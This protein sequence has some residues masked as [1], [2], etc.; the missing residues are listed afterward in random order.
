MLLTWLR[1]VNPQVLEQY[2]TEWEQIG[3][4]LEGVYQK[5]VDSVSKVDGQ[6]WQG[7]AADAAH[8]RASADLKT[9]QAL[10]DKLNGLA[11]QART[12]ATLINEALRK[13]R[14][15]LDEC[16]NKGWTV[17]ELLAVIGSGNVRDL[18][19]MN[20]DLTAAYNAVVAAD[21]A[22]MDALN[23]TRSG[24]TVAFTSGASLG[25]EQ[26]KNDG[27]HVG[28]DPT[29][30]TDAERQ[31]LIDAGT[32][33]D[34][35]LTDLHNG[36]TV[37]IPVAQ[38]DYINQLARSLD[39]KSPQ[40]IQAIVDSLPP[41][42]STALRNS[43]Q[44]VST[45]AIT[46]AVKGDPNI[47]DHGDT[48]LLPAKL[49]QSLTRPDLVNTEVKTIGGGTYARMTT[50]TNLNGV[51]DNQS[52]AKIAG[53]ADPRYR[54]GTGLDKQLLDVG[55]KYLN[56][57]VTY[58][59]APDHAERGFTVDGH[60]VNS[61]AALTEGIFSAVGDDKAAVQNLVVDASGKPNDQF[62]HDVLTHTWTDD[63]KAASKLFAF[64]DNEPGSVDA[65]RQATIMSAFAQFASTDDAPSHIAGGNDKWHLYDIPGTD[66]QTVGDLNPK[67]VQTLST[68]MT[69]YIDDLTNPTHPTNDG[70]KV[71]DV[72]GDSWTD[73]S[74]NHTFT[75]SKNIFSFMDTNDLAGQ[76]FN[77]AAL[78]ASM[79]HEI[80][81]GQDPNDPHARDQLVDSG[82]LQGLVDA[83][84]RDEISAH[85]TD[86]AKV[87]ADAYNQKKIAYETVMRGL[88]YSAPIGDLTVKTVTGEQLSKLITLGGDPLKNAV[89]GAPPTAANNNIGLNPPNFD[90]Q[91]Y[92]VLASAD[93]PN[94][95]RTEYSELFDANGQ[96]K[97]WHD[98]QTMPTDGKGTD[99]LSDL[100]TVFNR[101]GLNDGHDS[102]MRDG[103]S[104]V[105]GNY[106]KNDNQ[107]PHNGGR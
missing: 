72:N 24:L 100:T 20:K 40:E 19:Q 98:L 63:D 106:R 13:A 27:K 50:Y 101:L 30:L 16:G 54:A 97:P 9:V 14:G 82:R 53:G 95:L 56:A 35:Q 75:G 105:T 42:A 8:N 7:K 45:S 57:Q 74:K 38:M 39:N 23:L 11:A 49:E 94:N 15:L 34:D 79:Q 36:K 85:T 87:A 93:V 80:N 102:T 103:Y 3:T 47:P 99:P 60:G 41:D 59:Q 83:G 32:L 76:K 26:G 52:I 77:A 10:V 1:T 64:A 65:H 48:N 73:P 81:Y 89:I 58:E 86:N 31:R 12:G 88:G 96:L 6:Y 51:A 28:L 44:M 84:L 92:N 104:D 43:L 5:Y 91:A 68:S 107:Q 4:G 29:H 70:F 22:V 25:G 37:S 71:T 33:T 46:P 21:D 67:L 78:A 69:P 90:Q 2:A 66:H 62:F 61:R 17:T 55:A 18:A